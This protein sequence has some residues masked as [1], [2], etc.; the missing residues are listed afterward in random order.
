MEA[1]TVLILLITL[2][3][4]LGTAALLGGAESRDG[5]TGDRFSASFR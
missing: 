3:V 5:F 4:L 1:L 2:L